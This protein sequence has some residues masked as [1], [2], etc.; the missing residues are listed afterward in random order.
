MLF[1]CLCYCIAQVSWILIYVGTFDILYRQINNKKKIRETFIVYMAR[2]RVHII[3]RKC[4]EKCDRWCVTNGKTI[5]H[6]VVHRAHLI[7]WPTM[8]R[9]WIAFECIAYFSIHD[10]TRFNGITEMFYG[11]CN[12]KNMHRIL[13]VIYRE[14][15]RQLLPNICILYF[16]IILIE[17]WKNINI[18]L[19]GFGWNRLA[20]NLVNYHL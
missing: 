4:M 13:I 19:N 3:I 16:S 17:I 9:R 5:L 8:L 14:A 12:C 1:Y 7:M 20:L 15:I 11:F 6:F 18:S 10:Y 2:W